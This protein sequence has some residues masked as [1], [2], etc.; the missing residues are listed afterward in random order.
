MSI[1][2]L[3]LR[4]LAMDRI[5]AP[6]SETTDLQTM[7]T[8]FKACLKS[9]DRS[10]HSIR[11]YL[12]DFRLFAAWFET[13]ASERFTVTNVLDDDI[14]RW[15]DELEKKQKAST[16]NRNLAA[17]STFFAWVVEK[18]YA[19]DDPTRHIQRLGQQVIA[20]KALSE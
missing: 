8:K 11:A 7:L 3:Q 5:F 1:V 9:R 13:H 10:S 15:R 17:L 18:Q 19:K 14:K 4:F 12:S 16:V 2:V 6:Y 20:P